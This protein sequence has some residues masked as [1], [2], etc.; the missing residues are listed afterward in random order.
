MVFNHNGN[1]PSPIDWIFEARSYGLKIAFT[2]PTAGAI[3]WAGN[4][5]SYRDIHLSMELLTEFTYTLVG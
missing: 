5:F 4:S 3:Y 2:T 1:L